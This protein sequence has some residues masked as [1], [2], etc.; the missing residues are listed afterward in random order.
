MNIHMMQ[1]P[2]MPNRIER[3][4]KN[5]KIPISHQNIRNMNMT[6]NVN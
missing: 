3:T 2:S 4:I 6:L 5:Y 1:Q